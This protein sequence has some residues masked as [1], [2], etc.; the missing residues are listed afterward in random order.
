[1]RSEEITEWVTKTSGHAE[2]VQAFNYPYAAL[3]AAVVNAVYHRDYDVREPIKGR[4][5]RASIEP[6]SYP[7]PDQSIRPE[8]LRGERIFSRGTAT[9]GS[10][11]S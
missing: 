10:A 3:E 11:S 6:L 9:G 2:A 8:S 7:G 5:D 1:L 4:V